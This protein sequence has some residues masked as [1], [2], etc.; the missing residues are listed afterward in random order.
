MTTV[1]TGYPITHQL[2]PLPPPTSSAD[3]FQSLIFALSHRT[4]SPPTVATLVAYHE[5]FHPKLCLRSTRSYNFLIAL[6]IR[7]SAFG[8][9]QRLLTQMRH[10]HIPEDLETWKLVVRWMVR[11]GRWG[12][13][14]KD[15]MGEIH[16]DTQR[17]PLHAAKSTRKQIPLAVW[18]EFF[19]S[20][21]MGA[22][23]RR[24]P[25]KQRRT[26]GNRFQVLDDPNDAVHLARY[27]L[28]L[29]NSPQLTLSEK[30]RESPR[31]IYVVVQMMLRTGQKDAA[32]ELTR[33]YLASLPSYL[34]SKWV[35]LCLRIVHLHIRF[36]P[37][38]NGPYCT[39]RM[40]NFLLKFNPCLRPNSTTLFLLLSG[41]E[42]RRRCATIA[43]RIAAKQRRKW[44]M[45]F[46]D[47]RVKRRILSFA[48]KEGRKDVVEMLMKE[49][50]GSEWARR[51]W[52]SQ[53]TVLGGAETVRTG[54]R[55]WLRVSDEKIFAGNGRERWKWKVLKRRIGRKMGDMLFIK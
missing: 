33:S 50:D 22:L 54:R 12:D 3:L 28:L 11:T 15:V 14:W 9:V 45:I 51:M 53:R 27:R 37:T 16:G 21:K 44:G 34:S 1:R 29:K 25:I 46:V 4:A 52:M 43:L 18:T 26:E 55:R 23:R 13:A 42:A 24:V 38:S 41:L 19:G 20:T 30:T 8:S 10:E 31:T 7:H 32:V 49:E 6:A 35:K 48:V 39:Q 47:R 17:Y 5:S 2:A 36:K 40:V